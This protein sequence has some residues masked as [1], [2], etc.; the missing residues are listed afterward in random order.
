MD[1]KS[2]VEL[3]L[4][5]FGFARRFDTKNPDVSMKTKCGTPAF[6]PP[7]LVLGK[8][9]GPQCDIWSAG[10]TLF[11]LLSGRA[12][13]NTKKAGKNAMFRAIRA[14]GEYYLYYWCGVFNASTH[15]ESAI[16]LIV[17]QRFCI[18]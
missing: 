7:E 6:V 1:T 17:I 12:P 10:C 8:R 14:G 11:M 3:K 5:D 2:D 9:Y 16:V 15:I 4:A 13:F 18:L